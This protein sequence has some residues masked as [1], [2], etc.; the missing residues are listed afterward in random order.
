MK[1]HVLIANDQFEDRHIERIGEAL[2]HWATWERAELYE[3]L[4]AKVAVN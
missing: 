4:F 2:G 1:H 3:L